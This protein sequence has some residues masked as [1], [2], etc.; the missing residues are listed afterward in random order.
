MYLPYANEDSKRTSSIIE[1]KGYRHKAYTAE[2]EFYDCM[3]I[4]GDEYPVLTARKPR[5]TVKKLTKPNG[6][7]GKEKLCWIDGKEMYYGGEKV[8]DVT[9]CEKTISGMGAYIV[10][11]PDKICYNTST[12]KTENIEAEF[13][14]GTKTI[15]YKNS[16]LTDSDNL[17]ATGQTYVKIKCDGI[18][19][20]FEKYDAVTFSGCDIT[21][22]E[23][24][25]KVIQ[26]KDDDWI[27]VISETVIED[28]ITQSGG[29][30]VYREMPDMDFICE[31]ENRLWGCSI[32]NREIYCSYLGNPKNWK[33]YGSLSTDCYAATIGTDGAFTGCVSFLGY[34]I[35]FKEN[36]IHKVFGTKPS[37]FQI[38]TY[39]IRGMAEDSPKS[40]VCLNECLYYKGAHD[41]LENTGNIPES[42][43]DALGEE[44]TD[45]VSGHYK[46]KLY[47][48]MKSKEGIYKMFVYDTR[49]N[50]WYR[51]DNIHALYMTQCMGKLYY[52]DAADN[53][54]KTIEGEDSENIEWFAEFGTFSGQVENKKYLSR[55]NFEI[56]L[57][58]YSYMDILVQYDYT[59][60]WKKAGTIRKQGRHTENIPIK[61]NRCDSFKIKL[62]GRGNFKLYRISKEFEFGSER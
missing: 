34:L 2:G 7:Y 60:E 45:A 42:I 18:G 36:C 52:I 19:E 28:S 4:S 8:A 62:C 9:D 23:G 21:D 22:I 10:V 29:L 13:N 49:L 6:L 58:E 31:H 11:L 61:I 55:L 15:T 17:D 12:G 37:N 33:N 53:T 35:F 25:T 47:I 57:D 30:S 43:S 48:S 5:G 51:E 16:Y 27:L 46:D 41:V 3:N 24:T 38:S 14:S 26:D 32:E 54:I 39:K 50:L 59:G 40:L 20:L 44:Y 56:W 1:F